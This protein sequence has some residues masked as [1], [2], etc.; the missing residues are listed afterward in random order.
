[1]SFGGYITIFIIV[2][3]VAWII[4]KISGGNNSPQIN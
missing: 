4:D 3:F 2:M 1:M